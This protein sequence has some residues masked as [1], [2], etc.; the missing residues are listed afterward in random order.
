MLESKLVNDESDKSPIENTE[1]LSNLKPSIRRSKKYSIEHHP[2]YK[3]NSKP[4]FS[5]G[6]TIPKKISVDCTK[7]VLP[8][9][10]ERRVKAC[11]FKTNDT[12]KSPRNSIELHPIYKQNSKP[13]NSSSFKIPKNI[14]VDK[15][16]IFSQKC[17]FYHR[18]RLPHKSK[19]TILNKR[20]TKRD[21]KIDN[22]TQSQIRDLKL[23]IKCNNSNNSGE[24]NNARKLYNKILLQKQREKK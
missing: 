5:S 9:N 20:K 13:F 3:Q 17:R 18:R 1:L 11:I 16:N 21:F 6:F 22:D 10:K 4:F 23:D 8:V 24:A 12:F 2:I 14:L 7:S 15:D 19:W